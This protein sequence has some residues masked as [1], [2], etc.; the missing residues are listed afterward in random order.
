M[1]VKQV[2]DSNTLGYTSNQTVV[3]MMQTLQSIL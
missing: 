3:D 2:D 1:P